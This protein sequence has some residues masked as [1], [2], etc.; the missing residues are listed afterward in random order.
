M[1]S[2]LVQFS[3]PVDHT[4]VSASTL[5]LVMSARSCSSEYGPSCRP[6]FAMYHFR[7]AMIAPQ[8]QSPPAEPAAAVCS[9]G[10]RG[11]T[12]VQP[13]RER[14]VGNASAD[15][16]GGVTPAF[17]EDQARRISVRG[18]GLKVRD[19]IRRRVPFRRRPC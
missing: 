1:A 13:G 11:G 15:L 19:P 6:L 7:S 16:V 12:P 4:S 8:Y 9:T 3:M 18:V 14:K 2:A 5:P 17:R 10:K